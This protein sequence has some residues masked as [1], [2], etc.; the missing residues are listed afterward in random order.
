M[1]VDLEWHQETQHVEILKEVA[2][3]KNQEELKQKV[4]QCHEC[5]ETLDT[6][7]ALG[8]HMILHHPG[9]KCHECD[10]V[11]LNSLQLNRH[12]QSVHATQPEEPFACELCGLVLGTFTILQEHIN[13][14]HKPEI[15][16]C[17]Y[18]E[19]IL[20][21]NETLEEH[22]IQVHEKIVILHTM[23]SQ[24]N[25]L[26]E[27]F[28]DFE[29]FKKKTMKLLKAL[30]SENNEIKQELFVI[31]N[32]QQTM[33]IPNSNILPDKHPDLPKVPKNNSYKDALKDIQVDKNEAAI[34]IDDYQQTQFEKADI[35]DIEK[36]DTKNIAWVGTSLSE[37][38]DVYAFERDTNAKV[39]S[40]D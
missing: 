30:K 10:E 29:C 5:K 38:V 3:D 8:R 9:V 16:P 32:T 23:G 6:E 7:E 19:K 28:E 4:S 35:D 1:T 13:I 37:S 15:K 14:V 12:I 11:F 20:Y 22:M 39:T 40:W 26:T 25:D 27:K 31:R 34:K 36:T 24:V 17:K 2:V 33:Q 21:S 18:C